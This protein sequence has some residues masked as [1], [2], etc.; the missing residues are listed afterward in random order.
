[1][2]RLLAAGGGFE[3]PGASDFW[4]PLVGS[5][6]FAL[7]RPMVVLV[8]SLVVTAVWLLLATRKLSVVPGKLQWATEGV[9]GMIRNGVARD[10]LGSHDF[11][12]F[13]PLLFTMFV[14]ILVN[15]LFGIVP[16][17]Q[18]P[19][20]SRIGFP[21]ALALVVFAVYH[22]VGIKNMG[23]VGYF[24]H[25][26]PAGLPPWI[27]PLIFF[28]ELVTYFFTRPVTLALR[29]FGNMFAGHI[30]L[31]LCSLGGEYLLFSSGG[32]G[33]KAAGVLTYAGGF[34]MT[35]FEGFVE[36]LQAYVFTLLTALYIAG[37]LAQEH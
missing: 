2:T 21:V 26:V 18:F 1:V 20:M 17:V 31:L 19:T 6:Q 33:L 23:V 10:V 16:F 28:L 11:L 35:L 32:L 7:T 12:R 30:L 29:L 3:A 36:F 37:S 4:Q 34:V 13:V 25:M 15:N 22:A 8:L 27:V 24:K 14:L 5:G 9:Y